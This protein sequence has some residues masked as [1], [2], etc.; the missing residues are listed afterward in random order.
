MIL[1]FDEGAKTAA[2]ERVSE[3][4]ERLRLDLTNTLAGDREALPDLLQGVFTFLTD[5]ESQTQDLLLLGRQHGQGPL[6]LRRQILADQAVVGRARALVLQEVAK[7]R[8]LPDGSLE[9]ERLSRRLQDQPNLLR[10]HTRPLGELFRR[11]LASHL[12]HE[13]AVHPRD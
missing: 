2:A 9:G 12:V 3:L 11:R 13:A 8:I 7:L 10:R 6:D 1:V 5:P 4:P